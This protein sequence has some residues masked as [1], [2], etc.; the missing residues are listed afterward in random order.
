MGRRWVV[1]IFGTKKTTCTDFSH[2]SSLRKRIIPRCLERNYH[3]AL[4]RHG[5]GVAESKQQ[6][7]AEGQAG[8]GRAEKD[9]TGRD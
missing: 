7:T 4:L 2:L 3:R 6:E 5:A 8:Q 1:D 9:G